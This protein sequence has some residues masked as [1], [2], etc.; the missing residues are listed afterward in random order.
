MTV[1]SGDFT[2]IYQRRPLTS[3]NCTSL[4]GMPPPSAAFEIPDGI[5]GCSGNSFANS[6]RHFPPRI[7]RAKFFHYCPWRSREAFLL[8][9]S[10]FDRAC[11]SKN[12][13]FRH[14]GGFRDRIFVGR[15]FGNSRTCFMG[16]IRCS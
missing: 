10:L 12:P 15:I 8:S 3:N 5:A 1:S 16:C 4:A 13:V 7:H 2:L 11:S 9:V 14:G 6:T